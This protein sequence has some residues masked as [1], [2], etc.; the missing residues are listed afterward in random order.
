MSLSIINISAQVTQTPPIIPKIPF[1]VRHRVCL[2]FVHIQ[3]TL[4]K[5]HENVTLVKKKI[6]VKIFLHAS[7]RARKATL[8][9]NYFSTRN[10]FHL[11]SRLPSL[12]CSLIFDRINTG[13]LFRSMNYLYLATFTCPMFLYPVSI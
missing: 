12:S 1:S 5:V 11:R 8:E 6:C 10:H 3:Y 9:R 7:I 13:V 2:H 4:Q